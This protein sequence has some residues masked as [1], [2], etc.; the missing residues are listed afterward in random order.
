[1]ILVTYELPGGDN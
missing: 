1:M